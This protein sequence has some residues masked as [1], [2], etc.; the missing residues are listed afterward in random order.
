MI[1]WMRRR[2]AP[3]RKA[4]RALT[5]L[6]GAA[7]LMVDVRPA[8]TQT[9]FDLYRE[10]VAMTAAGARCR[11]FDTQTAAALAA[12]AAQARTTALRA[13]YAPEALDRGAVDARAQVGRMD[14]NSSRLQKAAVSVREAFRAYS[15]LE[16]M[17][18]PGQA[19][20]WR[21]DRIMPRKS[22]AWRLAQDS[23]AG[24]DRVVFGVAG[25]QGA[26]AVTVAVTAADGS[27]P[28][29]ARLLVR[30]A[31]RLP[32]PVLPADGAAPLAARAPL[33][34]AA[35]V[36]LAEAR[37]PADPALRPK[38]A[39]RAVAFRFPAGAEQALEQ[40]DPREAVSVE[41]L[42]PSDRGERV[43]T[44]FVEVGDFDAGVAFLNTQAR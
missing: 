38:G 20:D 6:A 26:E 9:P 31:A 39:D 37:A 3:W 10:R 12:G 8:M 22:A 41:F 19:G 1:Y 42:Y 23:F 34:A 29:A 44:A 11:L 16:R 35:K 40:L 7:A 17:A 30:D 5:I 24:E 2:R 21:A 36:I 33:R 4:L 32:E 25:V 28:Y 27:S 18:F 15:G 43:R 13:G 14:C